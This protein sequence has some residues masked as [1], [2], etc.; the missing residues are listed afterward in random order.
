MTS[1]PLR[2]EGV[3]DEGSDVAPWSMV[4]KRFMVTIEGRDIAD[5]KLLQD[6]ASNFDFNAIGALK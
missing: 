1:L 2:A 6:F 4:G 5:M 3:Y